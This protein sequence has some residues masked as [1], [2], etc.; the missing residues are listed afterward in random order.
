M[1]EW[2]KNN[3]WIP[4]NQ[5]EFSNEE[6][7]KISLSPKTAQ[8]IFSEQLKALV[9]TYTG[10]SDTVTNLHEI[11]IY[12]KKQYGYQVVPQSLGFHD[13]LACIKSLPY[14]EV[15]ILY[16]A[17]CDEFFLILETYNK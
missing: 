1:K 2:K 11:L 10:S 16:T 13:M 17:I 3:F 9:E 14:I 7:R 5:M 12:H 15:S 8:R 4:F 6:D